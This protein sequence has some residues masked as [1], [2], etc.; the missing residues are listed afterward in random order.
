MLAKNAEY[1]LAGPG[2]WL[3][4]Q[5]RQPINSGTEFA[6]ASQGH[7]NIPGEGSY[8]RKLLLAKLQNDS[9][10]THLKSFSAQKIFS[11]V[12]CWESMMKFLHMPRKWTTQLAYSILSFKLAFKLIKIST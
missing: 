7:A 12:Q 4:W 11:E 1:A 6:K 3:I 2:C 9:S 5:P 8:Q 10:T